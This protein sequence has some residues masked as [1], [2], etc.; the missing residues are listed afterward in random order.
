MDNTPMPLPLIEIFRRLFDS[1]DRLPT[2]ET[3]IVEIARIE[4]LL[5]IPYED[6]KQIL[7]GGNSYEFYDFIETAPKEEVDRMKIFMSIVANSYKL[8]Y[9]TVN[10]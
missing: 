6:I 9:E 4:K 10:G 2:K 3:Q 7:I 5:M 1:I 8:G